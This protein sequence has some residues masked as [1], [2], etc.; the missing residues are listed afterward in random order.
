MPAVTVQECITNVRRI[1]LEARSFQEWVIVLR[2]PIG[3]SHRGKEEN[4]REDLTQL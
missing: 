2:S 4:D 1:V 3:V